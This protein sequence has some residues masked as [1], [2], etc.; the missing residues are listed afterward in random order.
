M[1]CYQ[2]TFI[3]AV[4]LTLTT[5]AHA[6]PQQCTNRTIGQAFGCS[7]HGQPGE[8]ICE[9]PGTFSPCR[10]TENPPPPLKG[11]AFGKYLILDVIYAPPGTNSGKS[12]SQISSELFVSAMTVK[13][14]VAS[15]LAKLQLENRIQAAVHAVR[16]GVV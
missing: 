2:F 14:H 4:L 13:N 8:K 7:F 1:R 9:E 3:P 15:I 10:P 6:Q 11:T 12:N 5:Q 16:S